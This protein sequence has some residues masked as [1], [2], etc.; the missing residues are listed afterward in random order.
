M[1]KIQNVRK[2][3]ETKPERLKGN[4]VSSG[5]VLHSLKPQYLYKEMC[6]FDSCTR[7]AETEES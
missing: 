1:N 7:E 4:S 2:T 6:A 5:L 3:M